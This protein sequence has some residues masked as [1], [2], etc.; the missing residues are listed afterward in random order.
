[1]DF[2]FEYVAPTPEPVHSIKKETVYTPAQVRCGFFA[3]L[4]LKQPRAPLGFPADFFNAKRLDEIFTAGLREYHN[5]LA[6]FSVSG[7]NGGLPLWYFVVPCRTSLPEE[8]ELHLSD[9]QKRWDSLAFHCMQ[10]NCPSLASYIAPTVRGGKGGATPTAPECPAPAPGSSNR[11]VASHTKMKQEQRDAELHELRKADFHGKA[12]A[13]SSSAGDA[14]TAKMQK[15]LEYLALAKQFTNVGETDMADHCAAQ[16][17]V[18]KLSI[19]V[20]SS[21][22]ASV[23]GGNT[24]LT[25]LYVSPRAAAVQTLSPL[26]PMPP[27]SCL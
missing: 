25:P 12:E 22:I 17:S 23:G 16:A 2:P 1:V 5:A 3:G 6:N 18:L 15:L 19:M 20:Q 14:D 27:L 21:P 4:G 7:N 10:E 11:Q 9:K 8:Q 26:T 13:R 24:P